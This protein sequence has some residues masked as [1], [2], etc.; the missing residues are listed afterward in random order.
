MF[1]KGQI[2]KLKNGDKKQNF[3]GADIAQSI[4][5]YSTSAKAYKL[6]SKKY[7][8]LPSVRT[9]QRWSQKLDMSTYLITY[10]ILDS[11]VKILSVANQLSEKLC[12]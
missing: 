4:T 10:R 6:L 9:L 8:P 1:T 11:V 5:L 7:F 2:K 3:T 12:F